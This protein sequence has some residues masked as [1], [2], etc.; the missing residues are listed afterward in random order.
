LT[1]QLPP[2]RIKICGI[3]TV[4]DA[5]LAIEAGADFLGLIFAPRSPRCVEI[6]T[7]R[8]IA[9]AVKEETPPLGWGGATRLVG[10]FQDQDL[11]EIQA[12]VKQVPLDFIQLH[13]EEPLSL[14]AQLPLPVIRFAPLVEAGPLLGWNAEIDTTGK[15]IAALLLEPPK[16]SG[17]SLPDWLEAH[18]DGEAAL[19]TISRETPLFLAGGLTPDNIAAV[20]HRVRPFAVDVASGVEIQPGA[21]GRKDAGK[22]RAFCATIRESHSD[23]S[24]DPLLCNPLDFSGLSAAFTSPNH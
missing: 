24:G 18:P 3:T 11:A 15:R 8:E 7:A 9:L 22:L 12:V 23:F 4:E 5:R 1:A 20:L 6:K 16:G 21:P 14:A 13:G 19:R 2:I 10:V 17:L